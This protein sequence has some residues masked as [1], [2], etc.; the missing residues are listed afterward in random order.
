[1]EKVLIG[2]ELEFIGLNAGGIRDHAIGG[3]DGE[4]FDAI[5]AGHVDEQLM[6]GP[7][8]QRGGCA[9]TPLLLKL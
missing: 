6:G 5:G 1:M 4:A 8:K 9:A 2:F 7:K 3:H